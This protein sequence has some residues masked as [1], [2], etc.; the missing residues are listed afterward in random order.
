V[1]KAYEWDEEKNKKLILERGISFEAVVSYIEEGSV[2]AVAQGRG[3]FSHQKQFLV[4]VNNY[5][6]IVPYVEEDHRVFLKT[7]IP[8]RKMT[9]RYL[10]GGN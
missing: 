3:K 7:I 4:S 8:S 5:I 2:V 9:R 10:L 6:Y 1:S